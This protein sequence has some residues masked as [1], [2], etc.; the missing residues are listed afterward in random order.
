[1]EKRTLIEN[2]VYKL[3]IIFFSNT[4][5]KKLKNSPIITSYYNVHFFKKAK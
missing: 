3:K 5:Q 2:T 1:M 4:L